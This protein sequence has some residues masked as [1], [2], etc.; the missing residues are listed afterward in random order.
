MAT[1]PAADRPRAEQADAERFDRR[2]HG[3]QP[4]QPVPC[5]GRSSTA[6]QMTGVANIQIWMMNWL[7]CTRSRYLAV[8][9]G[10][11][12]AD[13]EAED[14][15]LQDERSGSAATVQDRWSWRGRRSSL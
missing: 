15:D 12:Q 7:R 11:Q 1:K 2:G 9:R 10:H 5:G 3:I 8:E 4:A 6:G 13:A 14:G